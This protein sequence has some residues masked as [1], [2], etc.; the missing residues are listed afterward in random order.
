MI[1]GGP[2]LAN[3]A[4]DQFRSGH[5]P[6][7]GAE[8]KPSAEGAAQTALSNAVLLM[9]LG[10]LRRH[11]PKRPHSSPGECEEWAMGEA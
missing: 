2:P 3:K 1:P 5:R 4:G 10:A 8:G 9:L 6:E 11:K 7:A